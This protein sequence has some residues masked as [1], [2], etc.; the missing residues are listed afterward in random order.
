MKL[1]SETA[2]IHWYEGM[3]LLPH[4][5]QAASRR[6]QMLQ[7]EKVTTLG[8]WW[9]GIGDLQ[10]NSAAL[11]GYRIKV[12]RAVI[13]LKDGTW[14][15]IHENAYLAETSFEDNLS[16]LD[17]SLPVWFAVKRPE[18]QRPL[19]H[20]LGEESKGVPRP[21]V[22]KEN[23]IAD[24]N[25][26]ENEQVILARL[27]NVLVFFGDH[28]GD[29]YEAI[30][31]GRMSWSSS[32]QPVFQQDYIPALL[33]IAASSYLR[34]RIKNVIVKL[35]NQATFLQ[36]EM[37]AKRI[38]LTA[39]PM[40]ALGNF[41][42]LQL[43]A[44]YSQVL[45]QMLNVDHTHPYHL[46][47]EFVRLAGEL[48]ALYPDIKLNILPYDH[49][50][51]GNVMESIMKLIEQMIEGGVVV[52]YIHRRFEIEGDQ[53]LCRID[54]EWLDPEHGTTVHTYLCIVS[55]M[56]EA[57]VDAM[58]SDYRV[59]IAPPSKMEE[60]IISRTRGLSCQRLRRIPSGLP[61]TGDL[62]YYQLDISRNSEFWQELCRDLFL[63]IYG[64]PVDA[65]SDISMYVHIE[66]GGK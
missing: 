53:R 45:Q 15:N 2:E 33:H 58:L 5:Y 66:P 61:D 42:R 13:R 9:W 26:G 46:Y 32:K 31:V 28:P 57:Q 29:K 64:I 14:I 60:L 52:D 16:Q 56:A 54:K 62:H 65:S 34:E 49:D 7:Q 48:I 35:G 36:G 55:E 39:D 51:I 37:A 50:N 44:S 63:V 27:F 21:Y 10:I 18:P 17:D 12:D 24:E 11:A 30:Q 22:L 40:R 6:N 25:S 1:G 47:L 23:K 19:V 38:S 20:E 59:K 3:F 41:S 43:S 8:S 4:H